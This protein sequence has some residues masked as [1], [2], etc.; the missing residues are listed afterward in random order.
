MGHAASLRVLALATIAALTVPALANDICFDLRSDTG[1]F[2]G[3]LKRHIMDYF[4]VHC[5]SE[6]SDKIITFEN[7]GTTEVALCGGPGCCFTEW[8][9][10]GCSC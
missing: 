2:T 1:P 8:D 9:N 3:T 10:V 4:C 5:N 6:C 7:S